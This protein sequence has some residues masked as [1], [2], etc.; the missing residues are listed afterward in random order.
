MKVLMGK[1]SINGPFSTAMLNNQ[2]DPE[3]SRGYFHVL[4][5]L[6]FEAGSSCA[7]DQTDPIAVNTGCKSP[8]K[9]RFL[10]VEWGETEVSYLGADRADGKGVPGHGP[11]PGTPSYPQVAVSACDWGMDTLGIVE[12]TLEI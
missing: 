10:G 6:I 4:M 3:G 9:P 11:N 2:R 12:L 5:I 1:S 7:M 8:T